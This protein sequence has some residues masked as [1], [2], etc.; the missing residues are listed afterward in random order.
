MTLK[1]LGGQW[2]GRVL[3]SPKN[4]LTRPTQ[5]ILRQAVFNICQQ[6]I[7][8]AQFLDLFAGSGA[9]GLEALSRGAKRAVFVEQNRLATRCI[10]D[11]I[12]LLHAENKTE[13]YMMDTVRTLQQL[14][15]HK[16]C[17]DLV[18]IDP[19]YDQS[20]LLSSLVQ[21]LVDHHLVRVNGL[22][23]IEDSWE[24]KEITIQTPAVKIIN[25]RR[26]GIARLYQLT[27]IEK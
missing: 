26:F 15:K 18:Y 1:I 19:P 23:F 4:S 27:M 24:N 10:R 12:Q 16:E 7:V 13:L 9:M 22:I 14:A 2:K 3:H 17:F 20:S 21:T 11:N 5:G 25:I 6:E 8:D